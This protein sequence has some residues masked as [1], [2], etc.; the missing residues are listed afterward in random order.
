MKTRS[1]IFPAAAIALIVSAVLIGW[2]LGFEWRARARLAEVS[3]QRT[4]SEAAIATLQVKIAAARR[5]Q[6]ALKA[7]LAAQ[8]P[9]KKP[10]KPRGDALAALLVKNPQLMDLYLKS[11][12]AKLNLTY[13]PLFRQLGLSRDQI[14]KLETLMTNAEAAKQELQASARSQGLAEADPQT[15]ALLEQQNAQLRAAEA[16]IL[17]PSQ[18]QQL[19]QFSAA[20]SAAPFVSSLS[21]HAALA[22]APLTDAQRLQLMP[23]VAQ[24]TGSTAIASQQISDKVDWNQLIAQ[25]ESFL[26]PAQVA[27]IKTTQADF[28][29][30][31]AGMALLT[32]FYANPPASK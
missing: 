15:T 9:Y 3:A 20:E 23:V 18:D 6:P 31:Q 17:T 28:E 30:G 2:A 27:V 24:A 7:K 22:G 21:A 1:L 19:Q 13:A 26:S 8:E 5:D 25:S 29:T 32:Q 12:L 10:A 4:G 11:Y 16:E 14:N